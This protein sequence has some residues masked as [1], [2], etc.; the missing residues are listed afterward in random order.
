MGA[1]VG[2]TVGIAVGLIVGGGVGPTTGAGLGLGVGASV[3]T[4]VGETVGVSVAP[5][6]GPDV[7]L[8][9]GLIDGSCVRA[10]LGCGVAPLRVGDTD[11]VGEAVGVE[12]VGFIDG[13][14]LGGIVVKELIKTMTFTLISLNVFSLS[15]C[16]MS[17]PSFA[18]NLSLRYDS[19]FDVS[20]SPFK[21]T[22]ICTS[23]LVHF[24]SPSHALTVSA[25]T[26]A[27]PFPILEGST[28][29]NFLGLER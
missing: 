8:V 20:T 18:F 3:G 26:V 11:F 12:V 7:G 16:F 9:L 23:T 5:R 2:L 27:R 19:A 25:F 6:V 17:G 4:A 15:T 28:S 21:A 14:S 29:C 1:A 24:S 22:S 13:V 10:E